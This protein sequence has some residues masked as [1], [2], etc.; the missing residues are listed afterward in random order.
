MATP[1]DI[2]GK[3]GSEF[4]VGIEYVNQVT[5]VELILRVVNCC[6]ARL[7]FAT[8]AVVLVIAY[9]A[10]GLVNYIEGF[11]NFSKFFA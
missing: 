10:V 5:L 6:F 11:E 7:S 2:L 1:S 8:P 9:N 3:L 4:A